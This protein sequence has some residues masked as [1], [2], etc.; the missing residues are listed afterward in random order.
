MIRKPTKP[1]QSYARSRR[2]RNLPKHKGGNIA[3]YLN[4]A[5]KTGN[6]TVVK[7]IVD[8]SVDVDGDS[9]LQNSMNTLLSLAA[10]SG[11]YSI[12]RYLVEKGAHVGANDDEALISALKGYRDQEGD[13]SQYT[14]VIRYLILN[15]ANIDANDGYALHTFAMFGDVNDVKFLVKHG[16]GDL[17]RIDEA[18]HFA[19]MAAENGSASRYDVIQYLKHVYNHIPIE[20]RKPLQLLPLARPNVSHN[21]NSR[22]V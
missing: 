11:Q 15:G 20:S 19:E 22:N 9:D 6:I 4:T 8:N 3:G 5:V 1:L 18:I 17:V 2:L 10:A 12:V 7:N 14:K 16:A 21:A 13:G